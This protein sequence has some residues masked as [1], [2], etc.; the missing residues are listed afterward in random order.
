MGQYHSIFNLDKKS[1]YGPSDLNSFVKLMEQALTPG[2]CAGLLTVL[3]GEWKGDRVAVIGDYAEDTDLDLADSDLPASQIYSGEG[4]TEYGDTLR[5]LLASTGVARFTEEQVTPAYSRKVCVLADRTP[6]ADAPQIVVFNHDRGEVLSP[7]GMG[8]DGTLIGTINT[9]YDDGTATGLYVLLA[10]SC[11]GGPRGGG[12]IH[13][14]D[15]LVGSWAG[16]HIS[17]LDAAEVPGS[18]VDITAGVRGVLA[19]AEPVAYRVADDGM[20]ERK[21][22]YASVF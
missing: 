11:K 12:D 9:G 5:D 8:D 20:V 18:A 10:A 3:A 14:D 17:V 1:T 4:F 15:A 7:R 19:E 22:A 2:P 16:D 6:G 21:T 13:S